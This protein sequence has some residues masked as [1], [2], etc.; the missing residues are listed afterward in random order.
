MNLPAPLP[1]TWLTTGEAADHLGV[2]PSTIRRWADRGD[3]P[4]MVT[5]GGHRR[6]ALA[7][8]MRISEGVR[9]PSPPDRMETVWANEALTRTRRRLQSDQASTWLRSFDDEGR[10]IGR[11]LGRR[12]LGIMLRFVSMTEGGEEILE[13]VRAIGASYATAAA[14]TGMPLEEAL[15]AAMFFRDSIVETTFELPAHIR[16]DHRQNIHLLRR[17]SLLTNA[18][19]LAMVSTYKDQENA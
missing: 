12:L 8:L 13:E 19:Q 18:I 17:M 6:F 3:L 11:Q 16:I 2:H 15:A 4:T 14:R 10:Q 9:Q 7:D 5:P 1:E